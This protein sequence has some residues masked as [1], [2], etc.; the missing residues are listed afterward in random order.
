MSLKSKNRLSRKQ[1]LFLLLTMS[2]LLVWVGYHAAARI[3]NTLNPPAPEPTPPLAVATLKLEP[4]NFI[5]SGRFPGSIVAEN[6]IILQSRITSQILTMPARSGNAVNQGDTLILLDQTEL[7]QELERL[8]AAAKALEVERDLAERQ[9]RR[10]QLL[11]EKNAISVEQFEEVRARVDILRASVEENRQAQQVVTTRLGYATLS[12]PFAGI[13]GELLVL[14]GEMAAPG[15][16]LLELINTDNLKVVFSIP[17]QDL[18]AI[19]TGSRAK[20]HISA[21]N[22]DTEGRLD[23]VHPGLQ[24]PGRAA[25]AEIFLTEKIPGLMPGMGVRVRL[26]RDEW[27]QVLT[28]P[29]SALHGDGTDPHVFI[30]DGEMARRRQVVTGPRSG[31]I[32]VITSGLQA[33]ERIITTPHPQLADGR[34]VL[35]TE[36]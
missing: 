28:I 6:H 21:L 9:F 32:V 26:V 24:P 36:Q 17:Q 34:T 29:L 10:K 33:G 23:R 18:P 11:V 22:H 1:W 19:A 14:P 27:D 7:N 25:Q 30:F 4:T 5:L 3:Q 12:A 35:G 15:R 13:V 20:I 31:A 16:P 8:K 2:L